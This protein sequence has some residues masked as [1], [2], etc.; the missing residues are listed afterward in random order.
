MRKLYRCLFLLGTLAL[1][2]GLWSCSDD[3]DET[4]S[5]VITQETVDEAS[6]V[7]ATSATFKLATRGVESF[8]YQVVEGSGVT[9]P[10]GE[11]IFAEAQE[12][13]AIIPAKDG[14]NEVT[15]YG[16]EG[17]KTYTVFFALKK[18][19]E[20]IVK[21]QVITTPAYTR[22]ITVVDT[23]PY[24]IKVHIE[25]PENTYYRFSF[26]ARDMYQAQKEQ[27]GMTDG[28]Y[29]SYGQLYKGS[30]TI[31]L[32]DGEYLEENP[33]PDLDMP[34][35]VLPGYPYVIL[36]AECDEE[37]NVLCEY[38]YGNLPDDDDWGVMKTTRSATA[39][40]MDSY[41]EECSDAVVTFNGLYAKQYVYGGSTLIE[42]KITVETTKI[43]E[44][45]ATFTIKPD[46]SVITY[47]VN[48]MTLDDYEYYVKICGE[49]GMATYALTQNEMYT[50]TQVMSTHPDYLPFEKGQ[51]YKLIVVGTY[52]E[53]Y[54]VQSIQVI[55][56]TPLDS[57]KPEA[58]LEITSKQD[59][60]GNP[61]RVWFNI[62]APGKNC[63]YIKYLMNYVKE[64]YPM[65]NSGTTKEQLMQSYGNYVTE[66]EVINAINS[67]EGYDISFNSWENT[68][69]MIMIASFNEDEKMTVYEGN[70]SSLPEPDKAR[71]ESPLFE[72]LKG[73]WT[74]RCN[75]QWSDYTGDYNKEIKFKVTIAGEPE[76]GPSSIN[77]MNKDDYNELFE[78]FKNSAMKNGQSEADAEAYAKTKVAELFDEYKSEAVRYAGKY[79]GQNRLVGLGFDAAHEYMSS[80][81]LFHD[82]SYS[83]YDTEELFYDY[84][85]KL[86]LEVS[87]GDDGQDKID[88]VTDAS[89]I[90]PLSAWKYYELYFLG[91]N[92]V[93]LNNAPTGNFPVSVSD[94]KQT[95]T[96][97]GIEAD[98]VMCYPS[99]AYYMMANVFT[100]MSQIT[101]PITLTKGW[102]EPA[103]DKASVATTK[104]ANAQKAKASHQGNRFMRTSLPWTKDGVLPT[105]P[106]TVIKPSLPKADFQKKA[107]EMRARMSKK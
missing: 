8:A 3:D 16:L 83:A 76:Q 26:G 57:S 80:W 27:F 62:K 11:V 33:D 38:D 70:S 56:F 45:S 81:D 35:Q 95:I 101:S 14:D 75:A 40:L 10:A 90:A 69:S 47:I 48:A 86:F 64:W 20:Y 6:E 21:S 46:E 36:I 87:K 78:Y 34:I 66:A 100:F 23:Q 74:A 67:S 103:S 96:I 5:V 42:S 65:L 93:K 41:T 92:S 19:A 107:V 4:E 54:S 2:G 9:A 63:S 71:V 30:K 79:R 104:M 61:W 91:Y 89:T 12:K 13:N 84:G 52:S 24:S 72:E 102:T 58:K 97:G 18:G 17:S 59:P 49:R 25:V 1:A 37:G 15:V 28:D 99:P 29:I 94:D 73:D 60:E 51:T 32:V 43:T 55:D 105:I 106:E 88:L 50:G 82:L 44:R 31:A 39:P 53:D 68:E 98:G 7:Y 85:P 22:L 77:D